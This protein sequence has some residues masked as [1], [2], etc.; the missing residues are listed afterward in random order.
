[1]QALWRHGHLAQDSKRC[2]QEAQGESRT[3]TGVGIQQ[4][5]PVT[6]MPHGVMEKGNYR[7]P[8]RGILRGELGAGL[9]TRTRPKELLA[10]SSSLGKL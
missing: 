5:T 2:P 10:C 1:M 6:A 3:P 7:D 4:R 9:L 8:T